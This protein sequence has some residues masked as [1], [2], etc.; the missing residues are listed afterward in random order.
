MMTKKSSV[1]PT[2]RPTLLCPPLLG[3]GLEVVGGR[4]GSVVGGGVGSVVVGLLCV[5]ETEGTDV[6]V[7]EGAGPIV[8]EL[9]I[10]MVWLGIDV[11]IRDMLTE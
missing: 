8:V 4:V 2:A 7:I 5:G 10:D 9:L 11:I 6:V 1:R 3:D